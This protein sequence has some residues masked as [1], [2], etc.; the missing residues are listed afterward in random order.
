MFCSQTYHCIKEC[1][2]AHEYVQTGKAVVINNRIH[3][4]NG[5][6]IPANIM[7]INL[8]AKIDAWIA[9]TVAAVPTHPSDSTFSRKPPPHATHSFEI[10]GKITYGESIRQAHIVEVQDVD[11]EQEDDDEDDDLFEVY[12]TE[13]RKCDTKASQLPELSWAKETEELT[14]PIIPTT[15]SS[16]EV[17]PSPAALTMAPSSANQDRTPQNLAGPTSLIPNTTPTSDP[18]VPSHCGHFRMLSMFS[19]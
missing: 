2:I 16:N 6:P 1:P 9:G 19:C 13:R 7:G 17:S 12:A 4:P 5:Q 18:V 11:D 14:A 15:T 8:Q 10:I 3:L